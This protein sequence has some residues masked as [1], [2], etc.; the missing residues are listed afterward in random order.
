MLL[1]LL[2]VMLILLVTLEQKPLPYTTLS[3]LPLIV[4]LALPTRPLSGLY[5]SFKSSSP[6]PPPKILPDVIVPPSNTTFVLPNTCPCEPPPKTLYEITPFVTETWVS[7][8]TSHP[9][10]P[11]KI[12]FWN[13]PPDI[14][15]RVLPTV[16]PGWLLPP[17]TF[18][19]IVGVPDIAR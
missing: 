15:T 1:P 7:S 18:P 2:T 8:C 10:P 4:T 14:S 12:L 6:Q 11:P 19:D 17:K 16:V 5:P 3:V 9:Q 13:V